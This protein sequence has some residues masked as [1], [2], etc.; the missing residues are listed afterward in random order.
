[1]LPVGNVR[2]A[3]RQ[4]QSVRITTREECKIPG[5]LDGDRQGMM[6]APCAW[7]LVRARMTK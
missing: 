1:M 2:M 3:A 6:S 4:L 7:T 5:L